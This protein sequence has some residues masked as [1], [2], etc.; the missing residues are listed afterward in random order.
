MERTD[1]TAQQPT[2]TDTAAEYQR[3]TRSAVSLLDTADDAARRGD[4]DAEQRAV[5]AA[6]RLLDAANGKGASQ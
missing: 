1:Q 4:T 6:G 5:T 3:L 2:P